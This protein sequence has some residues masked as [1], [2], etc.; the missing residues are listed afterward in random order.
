LRLF[1]TSCYVFIYFTIFAFYQGG[2]LSL[3]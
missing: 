2:V 3:S 1:R